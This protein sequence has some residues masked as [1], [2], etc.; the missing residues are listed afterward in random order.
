[1]CLGLIRWAGLWL[2]LSAYALMHMYMPSVKWNRVTRSLELA[3]HRR[4]AGYWTYLCMYRC[5][6][7]LGDWVRIYSSMCHG[8]THTRI[9][10][11]TTATAKG[12][13]Y[14]YYFT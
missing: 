6:L 13:Y 3:I 9:Y 4:M 12:Y 8:N 14:N 11:L 1:M 5:L 10:G 7:I 2:G